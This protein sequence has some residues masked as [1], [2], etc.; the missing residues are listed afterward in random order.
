MDLTIDNDKLRELIP[1]VLHEVKSET[2]LID[3]MRPWL[4]SAKAWLE[5]NFLGALN[6]PDALRQLA[7]KIIVNK[8][9]AEALPS[10]DVILTPAGFAVISTEGRAPASK[11]R[12]ERLVESLNSSVDANAIVLLSRLHQIPEW[13]SSEAGKWW[14]AT[15]V[16]DLSEAYRFRGQ[17]NLLDTYR[18][19]RSHA[20]RF[21]QEVAEAY[22]GH[23]TLDFLRSQRS[24]ASQLMDVVSMIREAEIRY[25][26][27]HFRDQKAKCPNEHELWHLMRPIIGVFRLYPSLYEMWLAEM[28][29]S[30]KVEPFN[31]N[32]Q[33]GYYF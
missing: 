33:G 22:V 20:L 27:F 24:G 3:K 8:A 7:L 11:E 6:P 12:V 23:A 31:N 10:L 26:T 15:F 28:G 25:I 2:P 19:M 4:D 5:E 17:N 21:E 1:N 14:L 30:F 9:F 16:S 13:A 18:S 29:D 32:I